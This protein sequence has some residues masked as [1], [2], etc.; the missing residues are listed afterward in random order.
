MVTNASSIIPD[1]NLEVS[2]GGL[3]PSLKMI[4]IHFY[5]HLKGYLNTCRCI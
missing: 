5:L 4:D 2:I 1:D 3:N